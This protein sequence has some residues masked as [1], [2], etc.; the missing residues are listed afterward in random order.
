MRTEKSPVRVEIR[1]QERVFDG[2]FRVDEAI[3]RYE[4]YD[5]TLSDPVR[6]LRLDRGDSVGVLVV[7][8]DTDELLLVEQFKYPVLARDGGW[9]VE[10]V[11]GMVDGDDPAD[12]A[13]REV[14]EEIGY[15]LL[16]LRSVAHFYASPGG[17]SER[18]FLFYGEVDATTRIGAGGGVA[19]EAEDIRV[20][21]V[22]LPKAW[23]ALDGDD[24]ADA[25]TLVALQWLR[26]RQSEDR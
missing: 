1:R 10:I 22:S 26:A 9:I 13:R 14:R 12:A 8:R 15:E 3:L 16:S 2:F 18:I 23:A 17:S 20:L 19:E 7:D 25:K 4:K 24:V 11:A 21:R 5:G 6:R